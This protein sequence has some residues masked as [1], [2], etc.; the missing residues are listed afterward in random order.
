MI[1]FFSVSVHGHS[2][3]GC[4]TAGSPSMWNVTCNKML[5]YPSQKACCVVPVSSVNTLHVD[6]FR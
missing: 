3:T 2:K 6:Q 4:M 1:V 5:M